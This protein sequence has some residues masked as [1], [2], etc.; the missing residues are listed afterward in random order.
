M[1]R[2]FPEYNHNLGVKNTICM[3]RAGKYRCY[4]SGIFYPG[5]AAETHLEDR[6]T[7]DLIYEFTIF[8][9]TA[10]TW[11]NEWV[12]GKQTIEETAKC[13][14]TYVKNFL[15]WPFFSSLSK[16]RPKQQKE[17]IVNEL[18]RRYERLLLSNAAA[19]PGEMMHA[20]IFIQ[21]ACL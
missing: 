11:L 8:K 3:S 1:Q 4:N 6:I 16:Q 20:Y 18:Y 12:Q 9:L 10:M 2:F 14:A 7:V 15:S 5:Q 17:K 19:S 21:K 13:Q